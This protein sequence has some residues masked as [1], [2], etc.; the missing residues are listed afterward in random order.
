MREVFERVVFAIVGFAVAVLPERVKAREPWHSLSSPAAHVASGVAET[1]V[2]LL[3]F[4]AGF[5]AFVGGFSAAYDVA[6]VTQKPNP[7]T[8]DLGRLGILGFVSYLL[9]PW[10]MATLFCVV[11]G[12]LRALDAFFSRR[13]LGMAFIS[14][15]H[16]VFLQLRA[17]S[18]RAQQ[19]LMLGPP[20]PDRIEHP[21]TTPD[22][23]LRITSRDPKPWTETQV[24]EFEERFFQLADA[25]L[26]RDGASYAWRYRLRPLDPSEVIRG[27]VERYGAEDRP[28]APAEGEATAA[29]APDRADGRRRSW[30]TARVVRRSRP[31]GG[32]G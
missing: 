25:A 4:G 7:T 11:E 18:Q 3:L 31:P 20:R 6:F 32:R 2:A 10:A 22:G 12:I 19:E 28:P 17:R 16:W 29:S 23:S 15:P 26:V 9:T 13:L 30:L 14:L 8:G 21:D 24:V 5:L 27:R 1:A